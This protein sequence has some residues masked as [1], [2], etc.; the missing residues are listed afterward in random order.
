MYFFNFIIFSM[1]ILIQVPFIHSKILVFVRINHNIIQ[2]SIIYTIFLIKITI[3]WSFFKHQWSIN[4]IIFL[5]YL[6]FNFVYSEP[7]KYEPKHIYLY[8]I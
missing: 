4:N 5:F 7:F 6:I 3:R 1:T 2:F 8:E